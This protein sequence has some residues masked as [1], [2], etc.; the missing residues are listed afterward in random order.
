MSNKEPNKEIRRASLFFARVSPLKLPLL[1][2]LF[3]GW[4]H[5]SALAGPPSDSNPATTTSLLG[6]YYTRF[7]SKLG[8]YRNFFGAQTETPSPISVSAT[9]PAPCAPA[10][11]LS[12]SWTALRNGLSESKIAL[13]IQEPSCKPDEYDLLHDDHLP[14]NLNLPYPSLVGHRTRAQNLVAFLRAKVLSREGPQDSP[15]RPESSV[16]R[17]ETQDRDQEQPRESIY[18]CIKKNFYERMLSF[19]NLTEK[20]GWKIPPRELLEIW[21]IV[22]THKAQ[23]QKQAQA[24][25]QPIVVTLDLN[26]EVPSARQR[27]HDS[28]GL[29]EEPTYRLTDPTIAVVVEPDGHIIVK[30]GNQSLGRGAFKEALRALGI[31]EKKSGL[32]GTDQAL[33]HALD[34]PPT[35]HPLDAKAHLDRGNADILNEYA[36]TKKITTRLAER[37]L[38]AE[39]LAL[40]R[41]AEFPDNTAVII[42]TKYA[43]TLSDATS[44]TKYPLS[45]ASMDSILLS[46]ATGLRQLHSIG[47]VHGD[48]KPANI[49]LDSALDQAA[50]TDF[51]L[52]YDPTQLINPFSTADIEAPELRKHPRYPT[53]DANEIKNVIQ[54]QDVYAYGLLA[55]KLL[56]GKE[57]IKTTY[58]WCHKYY[59]YSDTYAINTYYSRCIVQEAPRVFE[60]AVKEAKIACRKQKKQHCKEEIFASCLD[61]DPLKR[62]TMK[63]ILKLWKPLAPPAPRKLGDGIFL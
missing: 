44:P 41:Y 62:P 35:I 20:L 5:F 27:E 52:T 13:G 2:L 59:S 25:N 42:Q 7:T 45:S 19:A 36:V 22:D 29:Q 11:L 3:Y 38:T 16:S 10:R 15:P 30:Y 24:Q 14:G 8:S 37:N 6:D 40:G 4:F 39:G 12:R 32:V 53:K 63:T 56:L 49:L 1:G 47:L 48:L 55:L 33:L 9:E 60:D 51:G 17:E 57:A 26:P 58:H 31:K 43:T 34:P 18:R 23:W 46:I 61:P 50:I 21:S 54:K 28:T